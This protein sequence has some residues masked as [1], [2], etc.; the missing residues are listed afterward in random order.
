MANRNNIFEDLARVSSSVASVV[1]ESAKSAKD[2]AKSRAQGVAKS[3]DLVTYDEFEL[4]RSVALKSKETLDSLSKDVSEL[5]KQLQN[6]AS[7]LDVM[8]Q[9][10]GKGGGEKL[11][12]KILDAV[13]Q[14]EE[15]IEKKLAEY[16]L[17]LRDHAT[18]IIQLNSRFDN[19]PEKPEKAE[20]PAAEKKAKSS[21]PANNNTGDL[22]SDNGQ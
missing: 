1:F 4:I 21:K 3:V 15:T 19:L 6:I 14:A 8:K 5:K 17:A 7:T 10:V 20:K 22:F 18:S 13:K 16:D 2:S 11:D 12:P 9:Q